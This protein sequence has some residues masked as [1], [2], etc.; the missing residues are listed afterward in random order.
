VTLTRRAFRWL[1]LT[2]ALYGVGA[3]QQQLIHEQRK[4]IAALRELVD[5]RD[6][7]AA[8]RINHLRL[9]SLREQHG[10]IAGWLISLERPEVDL[11]E[12]LADLDARLGLQ[13][14]ALEEHV[15]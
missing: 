2:R 1:S 13:I 12:E 5:A 14:A 6:E 9:E 3:A 4:T 15:V 8:K 11:R 7:Q 10:I